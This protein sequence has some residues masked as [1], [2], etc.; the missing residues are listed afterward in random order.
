MF[1]W[2]TTSLA[3][4]KTVKH[5]KYGQ[6]FVIYQ[7]IENDINI[8][9]KLIKR[10]QTA[11]KGEV[12]YIVVRNNRGGYMRTLSQLTHHI[13]SS[14][15]TVIMEADG[16]IAS[17]AALIVFQGD[18]VRINYSARLLFHNV[19]YQQGDKL[20]IPSRKNRD[21]PQKLWTYHTSLNWF[22]R[23]RVAP[24]L[25]NEQWEHLLNGKD[26]IIWGK[27]ICKLGAKTRVIADRGNSC[28]TRGVK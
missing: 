5:K 19:R 9:R 24:M 17:A 26:V 11:K 23:T 27:R 15:G 8:Y 21:T 28:L 16:F 10:L 1:L 13:A 2:S 6:Q 4:L 25:T 7:M 20:V 22:K 18:L 3:A 12:V 14:K